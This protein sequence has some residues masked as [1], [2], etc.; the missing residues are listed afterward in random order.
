VEIVTVLFT[1]N[2][3]MVALRN[4]EVAECKCQIPVITN[5]VVVV[6]MFYLRTLPAPDVTSMVKV[7]VTER[8]AYAGTEGSPGIAPIRSQPRSGRK[9]VTALVDG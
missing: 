2:A 9:W 1:N 5:I 4:F 8:Y 3:Y 7:K 6:E